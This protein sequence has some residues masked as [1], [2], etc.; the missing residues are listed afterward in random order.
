MQNEKLAKYIIELAKADQGARFGSMK[1]KDRKKAGLKIIAIDKKNTKR[2]KQIIEKYGWPGF[3]LIGRRA[4]HMFWLIVQHADLNPEFQKQSLKLLKQ[5]VKNS[6]MVWPVWLVRD[7]F[8]FIK[9]L[10]LS[11][12][13]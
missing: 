2:A 1:T 4:S 6:A 9:L 10:I 3:D 11:K 12:N 5:A 13:Y 7:I 8:L